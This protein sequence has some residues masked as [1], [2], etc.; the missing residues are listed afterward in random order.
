LFADTVAS[1]P[2]RLAI[3][4]AGFF[5]VNTIPVA[6]VIFLT[7]GKSVVRAWVG[8]LQ[9]SFPYFLA[10]AGVAGGVLTLATRVGW[11]GPIVVL[12]LM[13]GVFYSYRRY[14]SVPPKLTAEMSPGKIGPEGVQQ[15][16]KHAHA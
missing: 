13:V 10:S 5:L 16:E 1:H 2:L 14:F 11:Q 9:L 3:A 15:M 8:L 6:V 7:E 12:S 4:T